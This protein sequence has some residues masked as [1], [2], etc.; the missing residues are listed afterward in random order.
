MSVVQSYEAVSCVEFLKEE[1]SMC[2]L[3]LNHTNTPDECSPIKMTKSVYLQQTPATA[4]QRAGG[5]GDRS[6]LASSQFQTLSIRC[7][8][9]N[10]KN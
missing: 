10:L 8:G 9:T 4:T 1:K 3:T 2:S 5:M 7:F 6:S